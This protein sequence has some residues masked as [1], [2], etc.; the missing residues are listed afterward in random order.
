MAKRRSD[1]NFHRTTNTTVDQN[2]PP[3]Q[4]S[5]SDKRSKRHEGQSASDA[6]ITHTYE[7]SDIQEEVTL[8]DH[9]TPA[10]GPGG[11]AESASCPG[12]PISPQ[13]PRILL[14]NQGANMDQA[15]RDAQPRL[16]SLL[17]PDSFPPT[18][19]EVQ[20]RLN[21]LL[22]A[23][24]FL[25]TP[26]TIKSKVYLNLGDDDPY[27]GF[28]DFDRLS[29]EMI[30]E[31]F[32]S[33]PRHMM[34]KIALVCRRWA[35]LVCDLSLWRRLDLEKKCIKP[36]VM[37]IILERGVEVLRVNKAEIMGDFSD[38]VNGNPDPR[39]SPL[40]EDR[41]YR[42]Q[43]L[44]LSMTNVA[45][46]LVENMFRFCPSLRKVSLE[47]LTVSTEL[48]ENLGLNSPY[49]DTLNLSMCSGVTADG[50]CTIFDCCKNL[51]ELNIAWTDMPEE[52][53]QKVARYMPSSVVRLN[54]SGYRERMTDFVVDI[55]TSACPNVEY[56]DIS[57]STEVTDEI[58]EKIPDR[59]RR[60]H[61]ICLS[62]CYRINTHTLISLNKSKSL[63]SINVFGLMREPSLQYL[64]EH[65]QGFLINRE[66]FSSIA[67]PTPGRSRRHLMWN[68]SPKDGPPLEHDYDS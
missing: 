33:L 51:T 11:D 12:S 58:I 30:L 53:V 41:M 22:V 25:R 54:F 36:G 6:V 40:S 19:R 65:M 61:T 35:R 4:R 16:N 13:A 1:S 2:K 49:L 20:P 32:H 55:M 45:C 21:N 63:K 15:H 10:L 42:L 64:E 14:M 59:L 24:S 47:F 8:K 52:D 28:N 50:I 31:V 18:H 68:I 17:A 60:L 39:R 29:D 66:F 56:L 67:R 5:Q 9:V 7:T 37:K 62:R 23:E 38:S 3:S 43:Y 44:D 34:C 48:L 27:R 26:P 46:G 57:D